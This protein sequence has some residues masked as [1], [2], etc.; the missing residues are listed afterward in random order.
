M[1]VSEHE[2]GSDDESSFS[3][4]GPEGT[5]SRPGPPSADQ[6]GQVEGLF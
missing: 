4:T 5:T 6:T 3:V 2:H 1:H